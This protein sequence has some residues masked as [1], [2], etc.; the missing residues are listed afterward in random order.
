MDGTNGPVVALLDQHAGS[1]KG[2]IL[3][4]PLTGR[5]PLFSR[6]LSPANGPDGE[7]DRFSALFCVNSKPNH[8]GL[9][10]VARDFPPGV[11]K[12]V[13]SQP[14]DPSRAALVERMPACSPWEM[15]FPSF[16]GLGIPCD[17][18]S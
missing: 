6:I 10:L 13:F 17:M 11:R 14:P 7:P 1:S 2:G 5:G 12:L 8:H 16:P 15:S 3:L 4:K 18:L 9:S